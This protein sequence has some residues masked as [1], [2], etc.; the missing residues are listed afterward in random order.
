MAGQ[1]QS[2]GLRL[3]VRLWVWTGMG[4]EPAGWAPHTAT[5]ETGI[6][7]GYSRE[8]RSGV[9]CGVPEDTGGLPCSD[10][11]PLPPLS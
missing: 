3:A 5:L 8:V 10:Y 7:E 1:S 11:D 6:E 2:Q 4:M 9:C